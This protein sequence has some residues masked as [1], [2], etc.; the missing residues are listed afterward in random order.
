MPR[1]LSFNDTA[2]SASRSVCA[3]LTGTAYKRLVMTGVP[4]LRSDG[5]LPEG[6]PGQAE[7]A[8]DNLAAVIEAS[9]LVREDIVRL[10]AYVAVPGSAALVQGIATTK[11]GALRTAMAIRHVN[12]LSQAGYFIE[13]DAEAI[14]ES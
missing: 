11:L 7:Q 2:T 14:R 12:A 13:I 10:V 6:L 8:F 9:G 3:V 5:G 1:Y 4:G